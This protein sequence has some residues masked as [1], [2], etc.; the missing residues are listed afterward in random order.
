MRG[1]V[2]SML[3]NSLVPEGQGSP[4]GRAMKAISVH[5]M[6]TLDIFQIVVTFIRLLK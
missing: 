6:I 1:K 5:P 4:Q 3:T 2:Q